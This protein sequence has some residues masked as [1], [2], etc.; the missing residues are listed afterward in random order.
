MWCSGMRIWEKQASMNSNLMHVGEKN[1]FIASGSDFQVDLHKSK[2]TVTSQIVSWK[3]LFFVSN[4]SSYYCI[5]IISESYF[6]LLVSVLALGA[7]GSSDSGNQQADPIN[8]FHNFSAQSWLFSHRCCRK[9]VKCWTTQFSLEGVTSLKAM[10][11]VPVWVR[12]N[13]IFM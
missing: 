9:M 11:L 4:N 12:K 8:N 5:E 7:S 1:R 10:L 3:Q 6:S 13:L 2:A